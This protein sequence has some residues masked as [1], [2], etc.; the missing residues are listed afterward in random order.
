MIKTIFCILL[1]FISTHVYGGDDILHAYIRE[2]LDG[3]LALRQQT[4]SL[5]QSLQALREARGLFL[6]SLEFSTRYSRAGGGRTIEFP[7]GDIVNPVHQTLNELLQ[8][9]R[10]PGNLPN[11]T[12]PFLRREEQDTKLRV[13]QPLYQPA[14]IYNYRIRKHMAEIQRAEHNAFTRELIEEIKT[15]YFTYLKM[16]QIEKLLDSTSALLEENLRVSNALVQ[17]DRA[18]E[19]IVF[20]ARAELSDLHR[21]RE[22]AQRDRV[23]A[24]S[25]FNFLLNRP[26]DDPIRHVQVDELR[27]EQPVSDLSQAQ[28]IAMERRDEFRQLRMAIRVAE[29]SV[30]LARSAYIPGV[31]LVYDFGIQG[32]NYR[33]R[34]DDDY[35]M[36][37]IVLRWN[38]FNG[39]QDRPKVE[40]QRLERRKI[41]TQLEE[42]ERQIALQVKRGYHNLLVAERTLQSA[43][44]RLASSRASFTIVQRKYQEGM[45]PQIEFLDA[46]TTLTNA[47]IQQIVITFDYRI[48]LA[49]FER[50][51]ASY[52]LDK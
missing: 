25:Y 4:F 45:A 6:P 11:V 41:E 42:L 14:T 13:V 8:Q 38:L 36:A 1:L 31:S 52:E 9:P 32:T 40:Q 44:E 33:I 35:W 48:R 16:L 12:T 47:E 30:K 39:F 43:A 20:R 19:E 5:E 51:T 10:F 24:A 34:R 15:T 27:T 7:I 17:A 49:E 2:G 21:Q 3:N 29:Q 22:E 50:I 28:A 18:T 46:R 37:S 23:L 26:L